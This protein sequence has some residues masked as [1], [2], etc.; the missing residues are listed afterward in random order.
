MIDFLDLFTKIPKLTLLKNLSISYV[1][2]IVIAIFVL[3]LS[4]DGINMA[5]TQ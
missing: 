2:L 3:K 4:E 1:S 5:M